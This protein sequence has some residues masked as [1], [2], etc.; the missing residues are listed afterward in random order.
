MNNRGDVF[1]VKRGTTKENNSKRARKLDQGEDVEVDVIAEI[2]PRPF[3]G[4]IESIEDEWWGGALIRQHITIECIAMRWFDNCYLHR[5][6][7]AVE[8]MAQVSGICH[9]EIVA[10]PNA[11]AQ[12]NQSLGDV[13]FGGRGQ[14]PHLHVGNWVGVLLHPVNGAPCTVYLPSPGSADPSTIGTVAN[15]YPAFVILERLNPMRLGELRWFSDV[16]EV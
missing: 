6:F 7:P 9:V 13:D 8:V 1:P 4:Y 2:P 10:S 15:E 3:Y 12:T 11:I 5:H 16:F 14:R